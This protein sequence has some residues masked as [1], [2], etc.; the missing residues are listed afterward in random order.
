MDLT[1]FVE[2]KGG[3]KGGSRVILT[4]QNLNEG[5]FIQ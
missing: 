4:D 1:L 2:R 3:E 5:V